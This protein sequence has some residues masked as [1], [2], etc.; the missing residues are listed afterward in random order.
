M[1]ET[2]DFEAELAAA[3][4]DYDLEAQLH[5]ILG[6]AEDTASFT[7]K[8]W[9]PVEEGNKKG[10]PPRPGMSQSGPTLR[11]K[12]IGETRELIERVRDADT[13]ATIAVNNKKDGETVARGVKASTILRLALQL[14]FDDNVEDEKDDQL[15]ALKKRHYNT[16]ATADALALMLEQFGTLARKYEADLAKIEAFDVA[17][18]DEAFELG[19]ALRA[20]PNT[21]MGKLNPERTAAL[22]TRNKLLH[23]LSRRVKKMRGAARFVF[24]DHPD[25]LRAVASEHDRRERQAKKRAAA[26]EDEAESDGDDTTTPA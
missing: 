15:A 4:G 14:A 5:T 3:S 23:L 13:R 7:E 6:E 1:T 26:D 25:L 11:R 8:H 2:Y 10:L 24:L 19:K 21:A 9:L 17:T 20:I 18:I 22:Q 16:P 12:M